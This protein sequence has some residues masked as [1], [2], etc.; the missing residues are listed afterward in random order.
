MGKLTDGDEAL[1]PITK[2]ES[3][4]QLGEESDEE[5]TAGD[6]RIGQWKGEKREINRVNTVHERNFMWQERRIPAL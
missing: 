5:N 3:D 6:C 1:R 4:G 2:V